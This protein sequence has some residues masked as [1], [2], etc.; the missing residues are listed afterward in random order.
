MEDV[1][2]RALRVLREVSLIAAEDTRVTRKLLEHHGI[3]TLLTSYHEQNEEER[4]PEL[5]ARLEA[6]DIAVV[7]DAGTP[8]ISDPGYRLVAAAVARGLRVV[9]LPGPSAVTTALAV[10]GL[11]VDQFLY[12]GY[13]PRKQGQ[14]AALLE[15]LRDETRTMVAF[16]APHRLREALE[17]VRDVLGERPLAVCRELT[18]LHEEV[19]RGTPSEALAHFQAPRGEVTLVI[20]GARESALTDD[21]IRVELAR[22]RGEG[23]SASAAAREAAQRLGLPRSRVYPLAI[24]P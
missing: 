11:P 12:V 3:R 21:D 8:S 18:K 17:D 10:S 14:R 19:F 4:T 5:L 16:E 20:S 1:T 6:G 7:T 23:L 15:G 9:A 2:L 13:L 22:L 24:E